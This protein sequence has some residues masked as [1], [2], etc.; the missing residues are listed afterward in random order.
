MAERQ[1]SPTI[2]GRA[3]LPRRRGFPFDRRPDD[4]A[5]PNGIAAGS[6]KLARA[7][8]PWVETGNGL[9]PQTGLRL[10]GISLEDGKPKALLLGSTFPHYSFKKIRC[11]PFD[12]RF[13]SK[14]CRFDYLDF[15]S[16]AQ[17]QILHLL[18][19]LR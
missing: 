11:V 6:P 9:Q 7:R 18:F 17:L 5:N 2:M 13:L 14:E 1:I 10:G 16:L 19:G 15:D 3:A 4:P 12:Q 8:L